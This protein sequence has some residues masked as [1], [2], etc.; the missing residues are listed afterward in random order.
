MLS[1]GKFFGKPGRDN[2]AQLGGNS[3]KHREGR[4]LKTVSIYLVASEA[5]Q[6]QFCKAVGDKF[7]NGMK[8]EYQAWLPT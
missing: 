3:H 8:R 4:P 2:P 6:G 7:S 5:S 1:K